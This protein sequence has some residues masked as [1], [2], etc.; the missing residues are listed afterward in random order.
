MAGFLK[1]ASS[2][3]EPDSKRDLEE[4]YEKLFPKI[5]RDFVYRDDLNL[6]IDLLLRIVDPLGLLPHELV[7][8]VEARKKALEYK[9]VLAAGVD[10]TKRYKDLIN[11]DD[12]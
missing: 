1:R 2:E 7:G 5:G 10:G 8:D 6:I 3:E 4:T 9:L 11:L 12:E